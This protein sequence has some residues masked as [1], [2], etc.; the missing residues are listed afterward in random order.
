MIGKLFR[1]ILRLAVYSTVFVILGGVFDYTHY[2]QTVEGEIT[3]SQY[4]S[5]IADR[6]GPR[7]NDYAAIAV[8]GARQGAAQ[9]IEWADSA[10]IFDKIGLE[11]AGYDLGQSASSKPVI[12]DAVASKMVLEV[13][14]PSMLIPTP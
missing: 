12:V 4:A 3:F 8:N 5:S 10:G 7:V 14:D 6:H 13:V 9:G 2:R 1:G 11:P